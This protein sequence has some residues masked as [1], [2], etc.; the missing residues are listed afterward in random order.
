MAFF[1]PTDDIITMID[2]DKSREGLGHNQ[3]AHKVDGELTLELVGAEVEQGARDGD[4]GIVDET[5]QRLAW[6]ERRF[7]L[8]RRGVDDLLLGHIENERLEVRAELLREP[9]R[10]SRAMS[11]ESRH[12]REALARLDDGS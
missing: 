12:D 10:V 2:A 5:R 4:F 9:R 1:P 3:R 8:L 11:R 7:D 6:A